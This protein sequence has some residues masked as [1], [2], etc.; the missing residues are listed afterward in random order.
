MKKKYNKFVETQELHDRIG[1]EKSYENYVG[2]GDEQAQ[3]NPDCLPEQSSGPSS[4]QQLMGEAIGHLQGR[5]KEVY[6]LVMREDKSLAE[7]AEILQISKGTVQTYID[8][9]V[10]FITQYCEQALKRGR[11]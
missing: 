2:N 3:A 8:R 6:L 1:S 11:V 4:P 7:T 10:A 9:A 5:Q